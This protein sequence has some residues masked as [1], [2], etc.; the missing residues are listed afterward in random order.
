M[1][2]PEKSP[3][4]LLAK[5]NPW[6]RLQKYGVKPK[7]WSMA[8]AVDAACKAAVADQNGWISNRLSTGWLPEEVPDNDAVTSSGVSTPTSTPSVTP[9]ATPPDSR[10]KRSLF[11]RRSSD[12]STRSPIGTVSWNSLAE[13]RAPVTVSHRVIQPAVQRPT[14][15]R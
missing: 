2:T 3:N 7:K 6:H 4:G 8:T 15:E 14:H 10:K 9:K 12:S 11:F 13:C 5:R 1:S